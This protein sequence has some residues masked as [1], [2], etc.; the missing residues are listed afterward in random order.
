MVRTT[1]PRPARLALRLMA[2]SGVALATANCATSPQQKLAAGNGIDPKYGVKASPRL[3]NEGDVIPKGGGRRYTGKP[4]VVAGQTYVPKENPNGYVRE[5]LASWYG[6]A[7]HGRMTA[8][9]EVFD[10]HSIAAAHPTLPL[11]SYARV[12]NLDNGYS[13]L[14][15]VNDRG[16][17]HAGRVMDVS[18]EAA[19]ALGFHRKGTARV[20]VEYVGKASV[21]GSDDRKLLASLRTD[22]RPAGRSTVMM[23]DLGPAE[24]TERYTRTAPALAFKPAE[25]EEAG[26]APA[27]AP[28]ARPERTAPVRAPIV[29]ASAA[30][31]VPAAVQPTAPRVREFRPAPVPAVAARGGLGTGA[32]K[33]AGLNPALAP[34]LA[35]AAPPS[36]GH[37]AGKPGPKAGPAARPTPAEAHGRAVPAPGTVK[38]AKAASGPSPAAMP[39]AMPASAKLAM[40]RLA[41]VPAKGLAAKGGAPAGTGSAKTAPKAPA[42]KGPATGTAAKAGHAR[43]AGIY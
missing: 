16:P 34:A 1:L 21:A 7:F 12:T 31:T 13:M 11:P 24:D 27:E 14:V 3:Y 5:G 20:R 25:A 39:A 15:R 28:A 37:A 9:G 40:A 41:A 42:A 8:N 19:D 33:V 38:L 22:G 43:L 2:V 36:H 23:A 4:Y 32:V 6:A 17:Y 35:P 10:R 30:V 18:E 29:L 26:T